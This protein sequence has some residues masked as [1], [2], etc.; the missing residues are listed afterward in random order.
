MECCVSICCGLVG[1]RRAYGEV[2]DTYAYS[3]R[4]GIT[5]DQKLLKAIEGIVTRVCRGPFML[6]FHFLIIC[7][8]V[9]GAAVRPCMVLVGSWALGNASL[10]LERKKCLMFFCSLS[11]VLAPF[12]SWSRARRCAWVNVLLPGSFSSCCCCCVGGLWFAPIL[13]SSS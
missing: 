4:E 2:I 6:F 5:E 9:V 10:F 7:V 3:F 12:F 8:F 1:M 13:L 11:L